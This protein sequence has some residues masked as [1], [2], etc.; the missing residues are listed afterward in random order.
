M[1]KPFQINAL[2]PKTYPDN[3]TP[4]SGPQ[5]LMR[6]DEDKIK[7]ITLGKKLKH[8]GHVTE[9]LRGQDALLNL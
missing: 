5:L 6:K 4:K 8:M 3:L 7:I 2:T 1:P 9:F